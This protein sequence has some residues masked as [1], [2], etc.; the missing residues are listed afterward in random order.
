M[1]DCPVRTGD[2]WLRT[3]LSPLLQLPDT[4]VFHSASA[5]PIAGIWR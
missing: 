2:R 1:H 4:V 3:I 5:K